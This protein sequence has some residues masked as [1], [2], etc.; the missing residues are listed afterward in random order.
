MSLPL[1][2]GRS[3]PEDARNSEHVLF[4]IGGAAEDL[5][6]GQRLPGDV[7]T[8]HIRQRDRMAGGRHI[9][10]RHLI[11]L[12]DRLEDL[13]ELIS[14]RG[15]LRVAQV[16]ARQLGQVRDL[17]SGDIRHGLQN[18]LGGMTVAQALFAFA[19]LAALLT[20]TP[21][22]DTA[23]TLR[24]GLAGGFRPGFAT[25]IGV[26]SGTFVWGLVTAVGVTALLRYAQ[27]GFTLL[28]WAGAAYLLWLAYGF[29]RDAFRSAGPSAPAEDPHSRVE[30]SDGLFT[31][32]RRGFLSN[33][34]NPKAGVFYLAVLP[35]FLV[36]GV[37]P[38][39][40][41]LSL[42]AVH[43]LESILWTLVLL[44]VTQMAGRWL[45]NDRATR[46]INGLTGTVLA[47]FGILVIV[48]TLQ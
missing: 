17:I 40:M 48:E 45:R 43:A 21:G 4:H 35:Q 26:S 29:L 11:D 14:E 8:E 10:S 7:F 36:P 23:L 18:T 25:G 19:G 42:A 38:A 32:W 22:V 24:A 20:I 3:I 27:A 44:T 12:R 46:A 41:G 34:L 6:G 33:V 5:L 9:R 2:G 15:D 47:V 37:A 16:N 28:R 30:H 1:L 13:S 39:L 31:N